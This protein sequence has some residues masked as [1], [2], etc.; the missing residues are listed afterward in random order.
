MERFGH[1]G[2]R[3]LLLV[4]CFS[5]FG[6][7][8]TIASMCKFT[9]SRTQ[10]ETKQ[11]VQK[12]RTNTFSKVGTG[13][14]PIRSKWVSLYVDSVSLVN[15]TSDQFLSFNFCCYRQSL[16]CE[17]PRHRH[18]LDNV[19]QFHRRIACFETWF[20]LFYFNF[21]ILNCFIILI[22]KLILKN[23]KILF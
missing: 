23:K 6:H 20:K 8:R 15:E 9:C 21:F 7:C 2:S 19:E 22:L 12:I 5:V 3:M 17:T 13:Q 11:L 1:V 18:K 10:R 16:G 4:H 14:Q